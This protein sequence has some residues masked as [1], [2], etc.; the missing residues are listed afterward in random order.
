MQILLKIS[1]Y[2]IHSEAMLLV[3]KMVFKTAHSLIRHLYICLFFFLR[4]N[5]EFWLLWV[6][7]DDTLMLVSLQWAPWLKAVDR[8]WGPRQR[9]D[10]M[11]NIKLMVL[12]VTSACC[13]C[14]R[15]RAG[16]PA[17]VERPVIT[18]YSSSRGPSTFHM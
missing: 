3:Y 2:D 4:K 15:S 6:E 10:L 18:C 12:V 1:L 11:V 5:I 8:T 14:Q 13:S 9:L 7:L 16:N 17:R